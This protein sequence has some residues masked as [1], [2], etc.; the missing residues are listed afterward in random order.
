[1]SIFTYHLIEAL[2]G[3]NNKPDDKFVHLSN[4]MNHVSQAV[5]QSAQAQ[6]QVE[7]SPYFDMA[8][9][10]FPVALLRGGKGLP[11]GGSTTVQQ[12]TYDFV[13]KVLAEN[14]WV[15]NVQQDNSGQSGSQIVEGKNSVVIGV[16]QSIRK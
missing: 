1:L 2:Q 8:T 12:E 14:S 10:D 6:W 13:Q 15:E 11:N 7:Q 3:A 4:L 5:P 9:E 16:R